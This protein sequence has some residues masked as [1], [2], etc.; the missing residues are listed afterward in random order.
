MASHE[1]R[2]A[3]SSPQC[4]SGV[5]QRF[6]GIHFVTVETG[7][8]WLGWILEHMDLIY[9]D[10][11]MWVSPKLDMLPSEYWKRQGHTC[12]MN[13]HVAVN[14]RHFTGVQTLLWG[15]DYPHHEGTWPHSQKAIDE[16]FAGVPDDE[17]RQII[18]GTAAKIYGFPV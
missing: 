9:H 1:R 14:N 16:M 5:L 18:G 2:M 3:S 11:Q 7:A 8:G 4:A 6:P 10:H 13:D 15:N 12:F 17:K